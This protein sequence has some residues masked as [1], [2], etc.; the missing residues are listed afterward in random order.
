MTGYE[1]RKRVCSLLGYLETESNNTLLKNENFTNIANQIS[2]DLRLKEIENLSEILSLS[3]M[4]FEVLTYGCAMLLATALRDI[5]SA[6]VYSGLYNSKRAL[7]LNETDKIKDVLP[8]P[9]LGG[10]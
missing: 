3:P 8:S 5:G 10:Q 7:C 1:L 4:E 9:F 2:S 6:E